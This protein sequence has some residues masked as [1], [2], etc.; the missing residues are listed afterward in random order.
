M[1]KI[2][3]Q[4]YLGYG[5]QNKIV[6]SGRILVDKGINVS[7]EDSFL[8][9]VVNSYKRVET[10]EITHQKFTVK[11]HGFK[12]EYTTN[13]E[14]YFVIEETIKD[15]KNQV[16]FEKIHYEIK[17]KNY[18]KDWDKKAIKTV[19][20]IMFPKPK[21]QYAVISDIDDTIL[22]TDVLS[23]LKW[24]IFYNTLLIKAADRMPIKNANICYQELHKD[25]NP[26]FYVSNSPCNLYV[27]LNRFL[28]INNFPKGPVFLRDY[29]L[30][31]D[32]THQNYHNHKANE[33][34]NIILMYPHLTFILIGDG[35]E[36]DAHI[37]LKIKQKYPQKIQ[38][39]F[40]HRL[41][42]KK[43]QAIIEKLSKGHEDYFFFV[44]NANEISKILKARNPQ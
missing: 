16:I 13:S 10:D 18:R 26:F 21:A 32:D 43:H 15:F 19:G 38:A 22:K 12:K 6:C 11:F 41:G 25:I 7:T 40:I 27:Y 20:E 29:G 2:E 8:K 1:K 33:V 31:P 42:D 37:Y 3:I 17:P 5:Y 28:R 4:A 44:E 35:A 14:G 23:T 39:I 9:T 36:K 30:K 34:E 24:K